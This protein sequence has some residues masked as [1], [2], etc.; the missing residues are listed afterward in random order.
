MERSFSVKVTPLQLEWILSYLYAYDMAYS[1]L[2]T[3]R[4][5]D[6]TKQV[7]SYIRERIDPQEFAADAVNSTFVRNKGLA[8]KAGIR[9][10]VSLQNK[11]DAVLR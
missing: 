10:A 2:V 11:I 4:C 3:A 1:I 8:Y 5:V 6:T 9:S 7:W